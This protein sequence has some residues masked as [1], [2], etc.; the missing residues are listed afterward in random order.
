MP[1]RRRRL[2]LRRREVLPGYLLH[3][4]LG[5]HTRSGDY[6]GSFENRTRLF[7][8]TIEAIRGERSDL[9]IGCR[10]SITDTYPMF[11]RE[12]DAIGYPKGVETHLPWR[13]QF[14]VNQHEPTSS[15]PEP[16]AFLEL[17][18]DLGLFMANLTVGSPLLPPPAASRRL[19]PA[20]ATCRRGIRWSSGTSRSCGSGPRPDPPL[21]AAAEYLQEWLPAVAATVRM[22]MVD[23]VARPISYRRCP[24]TSSPGGIA[25][26]SA[27]F[28]DCTTGPRNGMVSGCYPLDDHYKAR[29]EAVELKVL[30]KEAA[31]A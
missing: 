30:R 6:G 14:G 11:R 29:P 22:N 1:R 28:S 19:P 5:A 24:P 17:C 3:E 18:R 25:S 9:M 23:M 4:L 16:K 8:E 31:K 12:G 27:E 10:V 21:S 20:T 15:D 26:I 2:R 13:H 7:R